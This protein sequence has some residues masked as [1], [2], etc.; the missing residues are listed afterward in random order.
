[1]R[2]VLT[3]STEARLKQ[4]LEQATRLGA[5]AAKLSLRHEDKLRCEFEAGDVKSA[6]SKETLTCTAE[7]LLDGRR[8]TSIGNRLDDV[9]TIVERAVALAKAAGSV[10]HFDAYPAPADATSVETRSERTLALSTDDLIEASRRMDELVK[11]YGADLYIRCGGE[12]TGAESLLVTT[13]GVCHSHE[14]TDWHLALFAQQTRG[15]DMVLSFHSRLWGDLN[16][17]YD[18]GA[19]AERVIENLRRAE[20]I[21]KPP[22]GQVKAYLPPEVLEMF[23]WPVTMGISG[24]SVAKGDSPLRD[25]LGEQVL[26]P[27]LTILDDPHQPFAPGA[28]SVDDDGVP[29]RRQTLFENGVLQRFLYD[30]DTAGLAKT[31]PT[32]HN[33]CWP[34]NLVVQ[35]GTTPSAGLLESIDDGVF[36]RDM[37]GFGQSNVMNGDISGNIGLGF[38]IRN[39]EIVGRVKDTMIAGN[40]YE[41]LANNVQLSSDL[42]YTGRLPHA[43]IEGLAVSSKGA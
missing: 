32:G 20:T 6:G 30:L 22:S 38:R 15:T 41:L 36:I 19:L 1:M 7:V 27:T 13:G 8:G 26:A 40:I 5:S 4:G 35:P 10:A 12:R 33:G 18:V 25:R 29:T 42:D 2:T 31:G 37:I 28:R 21:A 14:R 43:V 39:G 17:A 23:L 3:A 34:N 24:R 9:G 16:E 11:A